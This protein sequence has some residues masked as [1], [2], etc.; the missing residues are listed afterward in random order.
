MNALYVLDINTKQL[1]PVNTDTDGACHIVSS[2]LILKKISKRNCLLYP[3]VH[4]K[5]VSEEQGSTVSTDY[6]QM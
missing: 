1:N 6:F 5:R 3:S 2:R 4:I